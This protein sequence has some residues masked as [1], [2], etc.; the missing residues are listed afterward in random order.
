MY[1]NSVVRVDSYALT[2]QDKNMYY[3]QLQEIWELDFH[4]FMIPLFRC[5]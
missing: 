2:G 3:S 4:G 5:N 1:Q